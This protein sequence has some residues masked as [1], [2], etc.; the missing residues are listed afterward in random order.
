MPGTKAVLAGLLVAQMALFADWVDVQ[1]IPP[2]KK[3][4]VDLRGGKTITGRFVSANDAAI[5]V[6]SR[7]RSQ[8]LSRQDVRT[9][10][11]PDPGRRVRNGLIWTGA[12]GAVGLVIGVAICPG[13]ANEGASGKFTVPLSAAG[14]GLGA[15]IGFLRPAYRTVY[16]TR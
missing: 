11:V 15:A 12:G 2:E 1:K 5:V 7:S 9:V 14:L 16:E 4:K 8:H 13:C 6:R 3:I 10:R